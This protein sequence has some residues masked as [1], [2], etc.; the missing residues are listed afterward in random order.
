MSEISSGVVDRSRRCRCLKV[1]AANRAHTTPMMI[2]DT[3]V[4]TNCTCVTICDNAQTRRLLS[5][6]VA[7]AP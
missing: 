4:K 1:R 5:D 2:D 6:A 3:N 7:L